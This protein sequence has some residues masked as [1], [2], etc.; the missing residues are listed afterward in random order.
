VLLGI[1][2]ALIPSAPVLLLYLPRRLAVARERRALTRALSGGRT[3]ELDELLAGGG[4]PAEQL[5]GRDAR[6]PLAKRRRA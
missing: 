3:P 4:D 1:S 2:I 5:H 6:W